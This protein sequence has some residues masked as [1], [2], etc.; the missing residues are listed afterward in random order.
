MYTDV[1]LT[2]AILAVMLQYGHYGLIGLAFADSE[3]NA[4]HVP[5][6]QRPGGG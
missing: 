6:R 1:P 3:L 2:L 4:Q 5:V